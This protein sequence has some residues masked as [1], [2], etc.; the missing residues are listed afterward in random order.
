MTREAGFYRP[1]GYAVRPAVGEAWVDGRRIGDVIDVAWSARVDV[2]RVPVPTTVGRARS[3]SFRVTDVDTAFS[4]AVFWMGGR[5]SW[6][7][8]WNAERLRT[9]PLWARLSGRA[10]ALLIVASVVRG[11]IGGSR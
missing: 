10:L 9:A 11:A 1:L 8:V 4:L 2:P 3:G 5:D 6:Q 7:D